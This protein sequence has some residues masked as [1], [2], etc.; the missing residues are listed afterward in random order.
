VEGRFISRSCPGGA[1]KR[2]LASLSI[3]H[4]ALLKLDLVSAEKSQEFGLEVFLLVVS[5][6][7]GDVI[8]TTR[9]CD[10]LTVNTP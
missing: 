3:E 6:L 4:I 5:G 8:F 7:P 9:S 1:A 10:L 2:R